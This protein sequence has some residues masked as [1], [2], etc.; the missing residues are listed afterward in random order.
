MR[1]RPYSH[2]PLTILGGLI[3]SLLSL[4]GLY[5]RLYGGLLLRSQA[6]PLWLALLRALGG[7]ADVDLHQAGWLPL[8]VGTMW[9]GALA[10]LWLD[11]R[12]G[13]RLVLVL[14]A[15]S[16]LHGGAFTALSALSLV[17]A[18]ASSIGY[19]AAGSPNA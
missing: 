2:Y 10:G 7:G 17:L 5:A 6:D 12:W 14:A 19:P 18:L 11:Q 15:L 9:F 13:R 1:P 16:A 4:E 3:G 8:V